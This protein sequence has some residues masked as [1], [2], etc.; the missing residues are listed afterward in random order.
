[1]V[2]CFITLN[3]EAMMLVHC[4]KLYLLTVSLL[5]EIELSINLV[6]FNLLSMISVL[7]FYLNQPAAYEW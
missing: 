4:G 7:L 3:L 2:Y 6:I 1:M 5:Q